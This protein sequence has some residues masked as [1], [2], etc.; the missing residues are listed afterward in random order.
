MSTSIHDFQKHNLPA[1]IAEAMH[2]AIRRGELKNPCPGEHKLA[3]SLGV[4][5]STVRKALAVLVSDGIIETVK[6]RRPRILLKANSVQS[7][8]RR[9]CVVNCSKQS[10]VDQNYFLHKMHIRLVEEGVEWEEFHVQQLSGSR[11]KKL[12]DELVSGRKNTCWV[13]FLTSDLVQSFFALSGQ[14]ALIFGSVFPGIALPSIDWDYEALGRHAAHMLIPNGHSRMALFLPRDM[15]GGDLA[16]M[17]GFKTSLAEAGLDIDLEV[18]SDYTRFD[19]AKA[20]DRLLREANRSVVVFSF[21]AVFAIALLTRSLSRGIAV[22]ES[23]SI[24]SRDD[25]PLFETVFPAID[26]Y[27]ISETRMLHSTLRMIHV[28]LDGQPLVARPNL[29]FP[30]WVPGE[31]TSRIAMRRGI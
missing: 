10:A 5:R 31:T 7:Q 30:K 19:M 8:P 9:V 17:R 14:P 23:M 1:R 25:H 15:G 4:S 21:R 29:I 28:L 16:A 24:L 11:T 26:H 3:E 22:P 6:G 18:A 2:T 12:L 20:C 13:L 27:A